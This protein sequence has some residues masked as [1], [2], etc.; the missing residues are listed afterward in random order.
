MANLE[1]KKEK[2]KKEIKE[3]EEFNAN[4]RSISYCTKIRKNVLK[5]MEKK[6]SEQKML[7]PRGRVH[8]S[9]ICKNIGDQNIKTSGNIKQINNSDYKSRHKSLFTDNEQV[10]LAAIIPPSY[11]NEFKE[12]F[13]LV[14]TERCN[15]VNKLKNN[16]NKFNGASDNI[17]LKLNYAKLKKREQKMHWVDM[18]ANLSK[19]NNDITKLK[20][21]IKKINRQYNNWDKLLK[22]KNN[23]NQ[24]L[25]MYIN[26]IQNKENNNDD[27]NNY[28]YNSQDKSVS[29][30]K[31]S[32]D[33]LQKQNNIKLFY[34]NKKNIY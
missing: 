15:L 17:Q 4:N 32:S 31:I 6:N 27:N 19:K 30:N 5:H 22:M 2:I 28:N 21:E 18:N 9:E 10:Q 26:N 34:K 20:S 12:R 33:N 7:S 14:E 23:E 16:K 3:K 11:L 25:N 24:R 8:I 1:E 13:E 29:T